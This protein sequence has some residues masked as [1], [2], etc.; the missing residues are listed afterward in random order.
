MS[1][2]EPAF[3][4][5]ELLPVVVQDVD[6]RQ[7]LMIAYMN[8]AA[9]E[10]TLETSQAWFWSRSRQEL[11]HKGATSGHYLNVRGIILDCDGDAILLQVEPIGPTCHTNRTSCFHRPVQVSSDGP[12]ASET[13]HELWDVVNQRL[14]E[15]PEGSYVA[16]LAEGGLDRF[17]QKVGEEATEVVIAAKNA[18]P[19]ELTREMADLWFHCYLLL[20][21]AGVRPETV[22]AELAR[23]RR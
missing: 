4:H 15:R 16:R 6:S 20:A 13:A 8:R 19:D 1:L 22:W 12:T 5:L 2:P 10:R 11:W 23:R 9:Y 17:A 14:L 18:D 7:V 3:N 21:E